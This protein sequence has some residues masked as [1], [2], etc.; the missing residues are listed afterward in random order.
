MDRGVAGRMACVTTRAED[1]MDVSEE[2]SPVVRLCESQY[3]KTT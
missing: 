3:R 2:L 1:D